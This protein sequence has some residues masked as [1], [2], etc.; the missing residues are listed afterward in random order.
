VAGDK[1]VFAQGAL[2]N[3][4][5]ATWSVPSAMTERVTE[6]QALSSV[7]LADQ[8][9]TSA[10]AT[11]SQTATVS[12]GGTLTNLAGALVAL[13][14]AIT[15]YAYDTQGDRTS[16]TSPTATAT[17][18]YDQVGRLITFSSNTYAYNGDGLRMSKTAS[19][20]QAQNFTW[21]VSSSQPLLLGDGATYYVYGLGGVALE[22]VPG[23]ALVQTAA[24]EDSMGTVTS[25]SATFTQATAA[26][27]Q[28]LVA[29]TE[30]VGESASIAGY[31]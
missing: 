22:Q 13:K 3:L 4:S 26:N 27:D 20:S 16:A 24:N 12:T 19:G 9:L 2:N 10:G 30:D 6:T 17:Y 5:T 8:T 23:I 14:P 29:V 11:G 1:L 21:D 7:A 18:T 25:V 15:S 31:S 28:V